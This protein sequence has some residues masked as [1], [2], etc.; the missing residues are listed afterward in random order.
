[1]SWT[2]DLVRKL[3]LSRPG[4]DKQEVDIGVS[5]K[6]LVLIKIE[7]EWIFNSTEVIKRHIKIITD[8]SM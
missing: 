3:V 4:E 6:R 7:F 8:Q 2:N 5:G 1:M